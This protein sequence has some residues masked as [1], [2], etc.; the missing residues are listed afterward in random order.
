MMPTT[1]A[2]AMLRE[3]SIL[4]ACRSQYVVGFRGDLLPLRC[5]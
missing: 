3:V 1:G 2:D 4:R 5:R